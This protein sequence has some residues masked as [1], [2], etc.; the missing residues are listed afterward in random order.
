MAVFEKIL[1]D[2][3]TSIWNAVRTDQGLAATI[4]SYCRILWSYLEETRE[5]QIMQYELSLYAIRHP[6]LAWLAKWQYE[7]YCQGIEAVF[8]QGCASSGEVS[9]IPLADLASFVLAGTD[10]ILLK[11]LADGDTAR[12]RRGVEHLIIAAVSMAMG[13]Q[14]PGRDQAISTNL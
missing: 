3:D 8:R 10:G 6:E 2:T 9:A 4:E 13:N 11:F 7:W 14:N 5:L 1:R 12:A